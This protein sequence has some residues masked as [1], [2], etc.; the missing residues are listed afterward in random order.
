MSPVDWLEQLTDVYN[1]VSRGNHTLNLEHL[2]YKPT[3]EIESETGECLCM[4]LGLDCI[5]T[6]KPTTCSY[7]TVCLSTLTHIN[8]EV[9]NALHGSAH[10]LKHLDVL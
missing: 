5:F 7:K 4:A 6:L 9:L 3:I 8:T 10:K 2:N 1:V